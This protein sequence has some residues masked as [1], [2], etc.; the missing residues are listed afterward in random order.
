MHP[1]KT[2]SVSCWITVVVFPA[3]KAAA[4][5]WYRKAAEQG[6]ASAQFNLSLMYEN[7]TVVAQDTAQAFEWCLKART[8]RSDCAESRWDAL[9]L[10]S[11]I[12]QNFVE[13]SVWF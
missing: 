13:A 6:L 5:E 9:L 12:D 7:G 11:R 4:F 1:L 3:D 10:W 8:G 2:A